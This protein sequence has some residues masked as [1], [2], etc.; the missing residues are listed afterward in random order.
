MSESM[1]KPN[2][3][4]FHFDE[5]RADS[6]GCMGSDWAKTPHIDAIAKRGMAFTNCYCQAPVCLPSRTSQL[7]GRYPW[8]VGALNNRYRDPMPE[9]TLSFPEIFSQNG[10]RTGSFG[11]Q[12]TMKGDF[13]DV[14]E[15]IHSG[16]IEAGI[17]GLSSF[18]D[19]DYKVI[20][21]PGYVPLVVAGILPDNI[22]DG[23]KAL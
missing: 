20:Q 10:Y 18:N 21:R 11:K 5:M 7:T 3:L 2:I 22:D 6:L 23:T 8:E 1:N 4:W 14:E 12:H 15:M 19:D 13:W 16:S 17:F 9:G